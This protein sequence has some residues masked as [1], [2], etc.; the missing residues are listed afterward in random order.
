MK[1]LTIKRI[2]FLMS[3]FLINSTI[4]GQTTYFNNLYDNTHNLFNNGNNVII[5]DGKYMI[6]GNGVLYDSSTI[7]LFAIDTSGNVEWIKTY[8]YQSNPY[9]FNKSSF[10]IETPDSGYA[11]FTVKNYCITPSGPST[12]FMKLN[13]NGDS[14]WSK[15]IGGGVSEIK[16]TDDNGFIAAG[17][18]FFEM[19]GAGAWSDFYLTKLDSLGNILWNYAHG[20]NGLES[21]TSVEF[22][23]D[24]GYILFG[25][26]I[27]S[28]Y[29]TKSDLYIVKTDSNGLFQWD[30]RIITTDVGIAGS[31]KTVDGYYLVYGFVYK[32]SINGRQ[33]YITKLDTSGNIIWEKSYGGIDFESF[34]KIIQLP[35]SSFIGVGRKWIINIGSNDLLI[36]FNQTGDSLWAKTFTA[37]DSIYSYFSDI[38]LTND[39]CFI[40]TGGYINDMWLLKVDSIGCLFSGCDTIAALFEQ[41][42]KND[43]KII[44]YP[45]PFTNFITFKI[46]PVLNQES[47]KL[48]F[49][50]YDLLGKEVKHIENIKLNTIEFNRDNLSKGIYIYHIMNENCVIETG[51]IIA[52]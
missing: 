7:D 37:N 11:V 14:L 33:G 18:N 44:I 10:F 28:V 32:D 47:K 42:I 12:I 19:G 9:L 29:A 48:I 25:T 26:I 22:T 4:Q 41:V 35:D 2:C 43:Y 16:L 3:C 20:G 1:K 31:L 17:S 6:I 15:G 5:K 46:N 27:D 40:I 34:D 13:V 39:N 8:D 49:V 24:G 21:A 45:N 23:E 50:L 38:Q 52:E 51:K 36:K 30:K